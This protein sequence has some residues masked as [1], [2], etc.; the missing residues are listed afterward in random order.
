MAL[1]RNQNI[2]W[3]IIQANL[4]KPWCF[5]SILCSNP[6]TP[7]G[8]VIANLHKL[9]KNEGRDLCLLHDIP[10]YSIQAHL[11]KPW[12]WELISK[13]KNITWKIV[14]T[15]PSLPWDWKA[16]SSNPNITWEIIRDNLDKDWD[17]EE[18]SYRPIITWAVIQAHPNMPFDWRYLSENPNIT[19]E[20]VQ[21][22]PCYPWDW[23]TLSSH[24]NI[25]LEIVLANLDMP[26]RLRGLSNNRN[27]F[28]NVLPDSQIEYLAR[29]FKASR[30]IQRAFRLAIVNPKYK[31]CRSRLHRE[32]QG[33]D[34]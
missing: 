22:N 17:W 16:L 24:K 4:D 19:W 33:L 1:S 31:I 11:D 5:V 8:V 12:N 13:S 10:W 25:T 6:S 2:T 18:I 20:I 26:W 34:K 23:S 28:K 14:Q 9:P 3:D 30:I 27:I 21:A 7:L 29:R 15:N 32:F